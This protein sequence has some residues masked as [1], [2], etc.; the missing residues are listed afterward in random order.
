MLPSLRM[1]TLGPG[2]AKQASGSL[3]AES[4]APWPV[5]YASLAHRSRLRKPLAPHVRQV[6]VNLQGWL[7][8]SRDGA[9]S[10]ILDFLE[11]VDR[12]G[13]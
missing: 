11:L 6:A 12:L 9:L 10:H 3:D 7:G 1:P 4:D 5:A 2:R 13:I 8:R